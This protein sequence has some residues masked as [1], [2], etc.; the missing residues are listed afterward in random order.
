MDKKNV[1]QTTVGPHSLVSSDRVLIHEHVFNRFPFKLQSKMETYVLNELTKIYQQGVTI[2]CDLTAYT[3]PYNYYKIIEQSPVKIVSCVGFYT[4]R[5]VPAQQKKQSY[6]ALLKSFSKSVENGIGI[7][8]IRPG[9]LKVA[10]QTSKLSETE[11]KQF[12]VIAALSV[13]YGLPIAIHAPDGALNHVRYLIAAGAKP[14]KI[15]VA[16]I[17]KGIV[18]ETEYNK[19]LIEAN[20]ILSLGAYVQL[21]DFGCSQKSKKCLAGISF[22]SDLI[23]KGHIHKLLI[24]AD[25]CWRWKNG[26]FVVKDYN[27]GS[28]KHYTYT[29]D[30]SL[31]LIEQ[32]VS[33]INA[34]QVL[35]CDNPVR[36]FSL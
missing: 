24:S 13:E 26:S 12:S 2:I 18:S 27:F 33:D 31:P 36:L 35:L 17:E 10:A 23:N 30:F 7:R 20:Q 21:S 32:V 1:V 15:F 25:S 4:P 3:K 14:E 16:H 29:K 19:R 5:Y 34:E 11:E 6:D 8:K 22:I 28:G 9:I